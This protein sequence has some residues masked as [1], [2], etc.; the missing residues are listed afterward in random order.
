MVAVSKTKPAE[1]IIEAYSVGQRHF[2]ENYI[3]ELEEKGTNE[4]IL[5]ECADIKWHFIG[6]LQSKSIKKVN[7][8]W[9]FI[10]GFSWRR[11]AAVSRLDL[12]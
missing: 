7:I 8:V 10:V 6:R 4:R 9:L 11:T 2:G 1:A 3:N 5:K 12:K